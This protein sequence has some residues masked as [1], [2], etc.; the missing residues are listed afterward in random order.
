MEKSLSL[1]KIL[2]VQ[3]I[4][5]TYHKHSVYMCVCVCMHVCVKALLLATYKDS[6]QEY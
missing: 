4:Y 6:S 3:T 1:L 5:G 2:N